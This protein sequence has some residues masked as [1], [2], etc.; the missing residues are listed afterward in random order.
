MK[1]VRIL[2]RTFKNGNVNYVIQQR[3]FLFFWMWVDGW[4]NSIY[5]DKQ[6]SFASLE[7]A[8][9]NLCYFDG[10]KIKDE[11]IKTYE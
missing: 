7:E 11:I 1:A 2:K 3:H 10:T 4:V 9:K 5:T 8:E 6:D